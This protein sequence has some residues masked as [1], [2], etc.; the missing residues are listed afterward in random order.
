[1]VPDGLRE[2]REKMRTNMKKRAGGHMRRGIAAGLIVVALMFICPLA[3]AEDSS[4]TKTWE[5]SVAPFYLWAVNMEGDVR[6]KNVAAPVELEFGDIFDSLE[7]LFTAH[8]EGWWR[9]KWGLLF[10]V[11]YINIGDDQA[12]PVAT[13]DVDFENVMVELAGFYRFTKGRHALEPLVGIRYTSLE[14]DLEGAILGIPFKTGED[15]GWV[16]PIIGARYKYNITE[17]W[18]VLLRGDIGGFTVGSDFTWNLVGL[19]YFQPWKHVGFA[20]GYRA[21]DVDYESGSGLSKF[22][23]DVLMYGPILGVNIIW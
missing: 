8:F 11:S 2:E 4:G 1:V 19:I 21:L 23:Y 16:D 10:D 5:F 9:Q 13:V 18:S 22:K 15:E 7:G 3:Y 12:T 14:V 6:I 17:K 20:G